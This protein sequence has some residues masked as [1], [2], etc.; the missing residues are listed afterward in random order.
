MVQDW[1]IVWY[2]TTY[3]ALLE[4]WT[5]FL[6]FIPRFLG[7]LV[8]LLVGWIVAGGIGRLVTEILNKLKFNQILERTGWVEAFE[9]AEMKVNF[10]EFLG[11]IVKWILALV[12]LLAAVETLGLPQFAMFLVTVLG[13]L[14]NVMV[15]VLIFVVAV[16]LA[17]I[18]GK[19]TV[20]SIEKAQVAY[21]KLAGLLVKWAI[22]GFAILAI[23]VQLGIAKQLIVTL[24]TGIVAFFVIAL[25][26]AFG[27]GGK[28][29][30]AE[31]L[32]ELREKLR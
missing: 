14:P 3:N 20:A 2:S 13:F 23:L 28:E 10:S 18:L 1:P 30:A 15:A 9:R 11:I 5:G 12:F 21:A 24:F 17:D 27:L 4:L 25:G 19:I 22:W 32:R 16:I 6:V 8:V 31:V 29:T 26:L 7:A